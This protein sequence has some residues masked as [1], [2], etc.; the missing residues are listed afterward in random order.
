[1]SPLLPEA[2]SQA[3]MPLIAIPI[4]AT[5]ITVTPA[6]GAGWISRWM[7]SRK[8]APVANSRRPPFISAARIV[9]R[10]SP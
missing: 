8:I 1:M 4:A 9:E 2:K 7:A 10:P 6:T 3:L 5:T